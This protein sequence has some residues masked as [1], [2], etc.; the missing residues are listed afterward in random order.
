[1][2]EHPGRE[3]AVVALEDA[4]HVFDGLAGVEADLLAAGVHGMS[5]ELHH[6][7]LH[8][9]ACAIGRL[10]EDECRSPAGEGAA[11]RFDGLPGEGED[12]ADPVGGHV[13]D[14]EQVTGHSFA[15]TASRDARISPT[16]SSISASVTVIGGTSRR[17]LGVTALT[18][19]PR[20]S[21]SA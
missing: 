2:I 9:V 16:A 5:T 15:P 11:E 17:A 8:R 7:H 18:I 20:S 21:R 14:V 10:L 19:R 6:C 1:M 3:Q 13:G 12:R 4:C